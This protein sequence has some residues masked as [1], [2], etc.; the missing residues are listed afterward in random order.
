MRFN[1]MKDNPPFSWTNPREIDLARPYLYFIVVR[2]PVEEYRYVGKGSSPSR[3]GAYARNV[4]RVLAGQTKRPPVTRD[5]RPQSEGNIKYRYVHLVLAAAV[6]RGWTI[7]HYPLENCEKS[8]Q[9]KLEK[10][11][12]AELSCNLNDGFSWF[13]EDFDRLARELE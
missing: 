8:E 10:L 12:I 6:R 4:S 1:P 3:M 9:T 5:G 13:V 2:S 7:E 11:R